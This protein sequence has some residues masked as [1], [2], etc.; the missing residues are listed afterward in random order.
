MPGL[1]PIAA[2]PVAADFSTLKV[3]E[4][5]AAVG[6]VPTPSVLVSEQS[7]QIVFH[8]PGLIVTEQS[9]AIAFLVV[10]P[11]PPSSSR[12]QYYLM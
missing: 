2:D 6:I 1:T 10:P 7:A 11:P 12:R 4:Q 9:A 3:S 8:Q 5:S